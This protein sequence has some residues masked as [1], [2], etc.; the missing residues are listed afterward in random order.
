MCTPLDQNIW[1]LYVAFR[2][3]YV[4]RLTN[5]PV[6]ILEGDCLKT[7]PLSTEEKIRR[8]FDLLIRDSMSGSE[9]QLQERGF[10]Y[11]TSFDDKLVGMDITCSLCR[12][13]VREM[14]SILERE[15]EASAGDI[16]R[17]GGPMAYARVYFEAF[18]YFLVGA[19]DILA[20]IN[21]HFMYHG[22]NR[23][24]SE[25]YFKNQMRNFLKAPNINPGYAKL[26]SDNRPWIDDVQNNRDGL[27]HKASVFLSI[28]KDRIMFSKRRPYDDKLTLDKLP[29]EDLL[30]YL[31]ATLGKLHKFLDEY[32]S[33]HRNRVPISEHAKLWLKLLE[34]VQ[35]LS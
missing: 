19:L 20:S 12:E 14:G 18:L 7:R 11:M 16:S 2:K 3:S 34:Q 32:T 28:E 4:D 33:I 31:D 9:A 10:S 8:K 27:A 23:A 26:L 1:H 5:V 13:A 6:E 35:A 22:D 29:R 25:F 17:I 15:K 24:L 21:Y 30:Q